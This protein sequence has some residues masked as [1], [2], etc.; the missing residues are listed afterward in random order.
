MKNM[1]KNHITIAFR[2]I[3]RYKGYSFINVT[4]LAIA[5]AVFLLIMAYVRFE[6]S[7]ENSHKKADHIYRVT[8]D[9]YSGSE[10]IV[11]DC[12]T[13]PSAGPALKK[14]L[15]EVVDFV[16]LQNMDAGELKAGEKTLLAERI[17]AA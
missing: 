10:F 16:R 1:L 4:G 11:T 9:L 6:H 13:Y 14:Q 15:P 7:Y 2:N 5:S 17:Y 8:L 3:L 12:E